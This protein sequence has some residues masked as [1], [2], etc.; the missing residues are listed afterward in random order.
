[1][2]FLPTSEPII[3]FYF[4][5]SKRSPCGKIFSKENNTSTQLS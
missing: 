4:L 1:M 5:K 3:D 2:C